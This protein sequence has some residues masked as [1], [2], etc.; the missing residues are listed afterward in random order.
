M[1]LSNTHRNKS[2]RRVKISILLFLVAFVFSSCKSQ[3]SKNNSIQV[4][5]FSDELADIKTKKMNSGHIL[6][7]V[8]AND[9]AGWFIFDTGAGANVLSTEVRKKLNLDTSR[10]VEAEVEGSGGTQTSSFWSLDTLT[11]GPATFNELEFIDTDLSMLKAAWG[12]DVLG[13]IGFPCIQHAVVE[14]DFTKP[15][16][17]FFDPLKYEKDQLIWNEAILENGQLIVGA[18]FD[19]NEGRFR[20]D[21][22]ASWNGII[23]TPTVK[24]LSLL[25]NRNSSLESTEGIG[26]SSEYISDTLK[27]F[28]IWGKNYEKLPFNFST[29]S[30]GAFSSDQVTGNIGIGILSK[31]L[32]ILDYS[33]QRYSVIEK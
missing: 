31:Y 27:T 20:V 13:I 12:L 7:W 1:E 22:G 5:S 17:S 19:D 25:E 24:R 30:K 28:S 14:I 10:Q 16:V 15:R 23:H 2:T 26:G 29:A 18:Q 4:A 3:G 21:A 33:H 6:I 32:L 11:I 9:L 8:K